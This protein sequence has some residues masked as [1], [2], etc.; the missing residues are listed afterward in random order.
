MNDYF[1]VIDTETSGLPK[2]WDVPYHTMNNWPHVLQIA[3]LIFDV[4]GKLLK[5]ENHYLKPTAFKIT[6]ASFKIHQLSLNFLKHR[7]KER[8]LVFKKLI[9]DLEKYKPLMIAHFVELDYHMV[10]AELHRLKIDYP[11]ENIPLFCT[12]KASAPYVKNPN[13]EYLKLNRF[14]KTL[15]NKRPEK[16]H[17]A[18]ADAQ[19]TAEIFF[20]LLNNK[21]IDNQIIQNQ[22]NIKIKEKNKAKSVSNL[23][24]PIIFALSILLVIIILIWLLNGK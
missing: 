14:Y 9:G 24:L 23:K 8:N 15:F 13:F 3:W 16:L 18:L 6:K 7:G 5:K 19:L 21:E 2:K 22:K 17:D 10:A 1:L 4:E 12:L 20:H 11:I